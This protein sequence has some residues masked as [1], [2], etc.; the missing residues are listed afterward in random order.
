[1]SVANCVFRFSSVLPSCFKTSSLL[2]PRSAATVSNPACKA[3]SPFKPRS[4]A[5]W[6]ASPNRFSASAMTL[7]TFVSEAP[8]SFATRVFKS[9]S[10]FVFPVTASSIASCSVLV[11]PPTL[12]ST[13]SWTCCSVSPAAFKSAITLSIASN[14]SALFLPA[15]SMALVRSPFKSSTL[16]VVAKSLVASVTAVPTPSLVAKSLVASVTTFE[17]S[18]VDN[19]A[20]M[21]AMAVLIA[22]DTSAVETPAGTLAIASFTTL[23]TCVS[24]KL[25]L[26]ASASVTIFDTS[27]AEGPVGIVFTAVSTIF[28]TSAAVVPSG[29]V[30]TA[31]L[32]MFVT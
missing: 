18:S 14:A 22:L 23:V 12:R 28:C 24:V 11:A 30:L 16:F 7:V 1:M 6:M 15:S 10:A 4:L 17:T 3:S 21:F 29:R 9:S 27:W 25:G 2:L 31:S 20:G 5:A 32:T 8:M 26:A 19:P 13:A